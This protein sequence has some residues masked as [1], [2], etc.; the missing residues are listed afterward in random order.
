MQERDS[1][2][3]EISS[4]IKA[5]ECDKDTDLNVLS[6]LSE[7]EL[8]SIKNSLLKSKQQRKEEQESWYEEW[9]QKCGK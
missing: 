3:S 8:L 2:L 5:D 7:E 4:L 6:F 1:L 9:V